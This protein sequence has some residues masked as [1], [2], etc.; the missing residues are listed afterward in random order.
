MLIYSRRS[1][2]SSYATRVLVM[3]TSFCDSLNVPTKTCHPGYYGRSMRA[4]VKSPAY[5]RSDQNM[6]CENSLAASGCAFAMLLGL[7][8]GIGSTITFWASHI[9]TRCQD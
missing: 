5:F 8:R 6:Y 7:R 3:R 1:K 4:G 2:E 9:E